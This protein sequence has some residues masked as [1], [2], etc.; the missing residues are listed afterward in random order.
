MD[1][2]SSDDCNLAETKAEAPLELGM[3]ILVGQRDNAFCFPRLFGP[4]DGRAAARER[5]DREGSGRQEMLLGATAMI[6]LARHRGDDRGLAV[7]PAA[8]GK[9]HAAPGRATAPVPPAHSS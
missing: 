6:A 8:N 1:A 7:T 5:E 2:A 4:H 3:K 9:P